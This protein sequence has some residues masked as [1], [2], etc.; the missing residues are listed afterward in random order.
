MKKLLAIIVLG[1]SWFNTAKAECTPGFSP[2]DD[3]C[4]QYLGSSEYASIYFDYKD[5]KSL[6]DKGEFYEHDVNIYHHH[7]VKEKKHSL[8]AKQLII[9][10]KPQENWR[11]VKSAEIHLELF[12]KSRLYSFRRIILYEDLPQTPG[13]GK[14]LLDSKDPKLW[15]KGLQTGI[16]VAN[17]GVRWATAFKDDEWFK[18]LQFVC[19]SSG[20][21]IYR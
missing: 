9:F 19:R 12:C 10:N 4:W 15:P 16:F 2:Y 8:L 3:T 21:N 7:Y 13:K 14:V 20:K 6:K 18:Y 17:D 5:W 11:N 1:L